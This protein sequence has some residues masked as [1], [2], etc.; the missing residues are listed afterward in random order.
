MALNGHT[1]TNDVEI[2][3]SPNGKKIYR[4]VKS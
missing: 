3:I 4:Q 1:L 2:V